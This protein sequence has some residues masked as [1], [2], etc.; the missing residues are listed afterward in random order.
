MKATIVP[1]GNSRGI[2]IPRTILEEC[3]IHDEVNLDVEGDTILIKPVKR[4]PRRNWE[5][6]F[7]RMRERREDELLVYDA[8]D[9]DDPDWEW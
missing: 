7:Q 9:L 2:R 8:I 5:R 4:R 3:N 6:S 1:I